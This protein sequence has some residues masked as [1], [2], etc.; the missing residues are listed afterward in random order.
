MSQGASARRSEA[1]AKREKAKALLKAGL[2][3]QAVAL[4]LDLSAKTLYLIQQE[5]KCR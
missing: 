2:N 3:P 1:A 4:R 5:M